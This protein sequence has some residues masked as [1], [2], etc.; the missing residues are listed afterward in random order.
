VRT[1]A[2][3]SRLPCMAVQKLVL[4]VPDSSPGRVKMRLGLNVFDFYVAKG[5]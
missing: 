4:Q 1:P 5:N 2:A 3:S